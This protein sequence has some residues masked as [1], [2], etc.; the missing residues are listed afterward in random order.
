MCKKLSLELRGAWGRHECRGP[1][2][3]ADQHDSRGALRCLPRSTYAGDNESR[4]NLVGF[5]VRG[6]NG[7]IRANQNS[8]VRK[9]LGARREAV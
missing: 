6:V 1:R 5:R 9:V 4:K 2:V 3:T 7:R 8:L